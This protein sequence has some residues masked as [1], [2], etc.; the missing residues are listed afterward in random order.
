MGVK[1]PGTGRDTF[2]FR[3]LNSSSRTDSPLPTASLS[4]LSQHRDAVQDY[5]RVLSV[6][7]F[8]IMTSE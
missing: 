5:G 8:G 3:M 6:N 1:A 7:L 2:A 4:V